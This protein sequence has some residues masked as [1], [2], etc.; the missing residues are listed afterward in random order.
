M[1][2]DSK[3]CVS[4]FSMLADTTRIK[5]LK[6]LQKERFNVTELTVQMHVTQPTI[7]HHLKQLETYGFVRKEKQGRET[8]YI[9]NDDYP[10]KGCGVFWAPIKI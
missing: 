7:S 4:C 3:K 5:I 8:Y 6:A 9:F 1:F 10:C 2:Q